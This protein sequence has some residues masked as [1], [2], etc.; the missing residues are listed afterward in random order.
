L[1]QVELTSEDET[2][3][4]EA[5]LLPDAGSRWQAAQSGEQTTRLSFDVPQRVRRIQLLFHEDQHPRTREFVLRWSLD[6]QSYR[7]IV[8]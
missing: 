6:G 5:A 8:R 4:I 1:A 3:P 7:E 2:Y